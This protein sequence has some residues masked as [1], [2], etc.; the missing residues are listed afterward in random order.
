MTQKPIPRDPHPDNALI[1]DIISEPA[2]QSGRSGG[3][4]AEEIASRDEERWATGGD[5]EPTRPTKGDKPQPNIPTRSDH[6]AAQTVGS[7]FDER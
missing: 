2:A 4:L 7:D 1:D 5:P 6:Q 3:R